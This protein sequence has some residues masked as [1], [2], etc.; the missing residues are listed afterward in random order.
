MHRRFA[1]LGMACGAILLVSSFL[2]LPMPPLA[3]Q[4]A[5]KPEAKPPAPKTFTVAKETFKLDVTLK[6]SLDADA[7]TEI[8]VRP[9]QWSSFQ[10]LNA[11]PHGSTVKKGDNLVTLDLTKIDEAI[12]EMEHARVTSELALRLAIEDLRFMEMTVPMDLEQAEVS[13]R[14][15]DEDMEQ[16]FEKGKPLALEQA[17]QNLK[18]SRHNLEYTTEELKQLEK[19]YRAKDLTEETEEL[20]LKRQ[21]RAVESAAFYLKMAENRH[22]QS[23]KFDLPRQERNV[24]ESNKRASIALDKAKTTLPMQ[25]RQKKLDVERMQREREKSDERLAKLKKDRELMLMAAPTDGILYYGKFIR[26]QWN[27]AA[28]IEQMLANGSMPTNQVIMTIVHPSKLSIRA[29]V[30][31]KDRGKIKPGQKGKVTINAFPNEKKSATLKAIH[32]VPS[33]GSGFEAVLAFNDAIANGA[34]MPTMGV[35]VKLNVYSK[36]NALTLPSSAIFAEEDDEDQT[37]VWLYKSEG[38][39]E[40]RSV[41]VGEK[42]GSKTEILEGLKEGDQVLQ[43]KPEGESK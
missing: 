38:K 8:M 14:Q 23:M 12:K 37:Y 9:E 42:S 41:K 32:P 15:S 5:T 31:E 34:L 25:L 27:N 7:V 36:D 6:G 4:Q 26:G 21:R 10:V 28:S 13:K 29:T 40:K 2:T 35:S 33:I 39:P 20:I 30:E 43:T 11:M 16:F 22:E 1:F 24:V 3:A 18:M 19:M 17:E